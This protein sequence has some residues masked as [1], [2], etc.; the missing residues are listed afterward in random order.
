MSFHFSAGEYSVVEVGSDD[1]PDQ[2]LQ[3]FTSNP[4]FL[5]DST[6]RTAKRSFGEEGIE[7]FLS[8]G[9]SDVIYRMVAESRVR[10]NRTAIRQ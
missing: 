8:H 4:E 6:L 9:E 3:V 7:M 10:A 5:D 2:F 1:H